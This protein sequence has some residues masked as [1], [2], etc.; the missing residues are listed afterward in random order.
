MT[1]APFP[2]PPIVRCGGSYASTVPQAVS[3]PSAARSN[4]RPPTRGSIAQST[5]SGPVWTRDSG[6]QRAKSPAKSANARAGVARTVTLLTIGGT[7]KRAI[8]TPP[9]P[10]R[11]LPPFRQVP[12]AT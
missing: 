6:H 3:C 1:L 7:G 8:V 9:A 5:G 12:R 11:S 4:T 2:V 10:C